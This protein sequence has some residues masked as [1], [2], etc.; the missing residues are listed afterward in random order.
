M[1][2][3]VQTKR[4]KPDKD[5][6][7]HA[8]DAS[9]PGSLQ[10]ATSDVDLKVYR[11]NQ[12][13]RLE[14]ERFVQEIELLSTRNVNLV[15]QL[16]ELEEMLEQAR[17]EVARAL[18]L[19]DE[20]RRL[21]E[22]LAQKERELESADSRVKAL[23]AELELARREANQGAAELQTL[24]ESERRR[25]SV[26]DEERQ[27]A[28]RRIE[29]L[30]AMVL[31]LK[32]Q[33]LAGAS[34][35]LSRRRKVSPSAVVCGSPYELLTEQLRG[36]LGSMASS[37]VQQIYRRCGFDQAE[38]SP[39]KLGTVL[40]RLETTCPKLVQNQEEQAAL[41][42][43][44]ESCRRLLMEKAAAPP[45]VSDQA[46]AP[47]ERPQPLP[48]VELEPEPSL[49][50]E[51]QPPASAPA[52]EEPPASAPAQDQPP[53][54]APVEDQPSST[55]APSPAAVAPSGPAA[56]PADIVRA[57]RLAETTTRAQ[58][59]FQRLLPASIGKS[60][61]A[62]A[63]P[64]AS[65]SP[66]PDLRPARE[67]ELL[68]QVQAGRRLLEE[69]DPE[70]ALAHFE[71][72]EKQRSDCLEVVLG[73]FHSLTASRQWV[74]AHAVGA[75]LYGKL[76]GDEADDYRDA[77][78]AVLKE[79]LGELRS[80]A[81]RKKVLLELAELNL[82]D[83]KQAVRYLR[84]A[85]LLPDR[86][87][88][89][90]KIYYHLCSLLFGSQEDRTPYLLGYMRSLTNRPEMFRH[91]EQIY[92]DPRHSSAQ[93][94]ARAVL[95]LARKSRAEAEQMEIR[96][97]RSLAP[98]RPDH[99]LL[100]KA[101]TPIEA[102]VVKF[103]LDHLL[104]LSGV[105]LQARC[106]EYEDRMSRSLEAPEAGAVPR[107]IRQAAAVLGLEGLTVRC[108]RDGAPFLLDAGAGGVVYHLHAERLPQAELRFLVYRKLLQLQRRHLE[109]YRTAQNLDKRGR[110]RLVKTYLDLFRNAGSPIPDQLVAQLER[111]P[112]EPQDFDE[113]LCSIL[114]RLHQETRSDAFLDLKEFLF[115]QRPFSEH[116]D[117]AADR[118]ASAVSGLSAACYALTRNYL[119]DG[120]LMERV[121]REGLQVLYENPTQELEGLRGRLQWLWADR[122]QAVS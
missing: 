71:Q 18:R 40:E 14:N 59:F 22:E 105:P 116:L 84:Q 21:R 86:I 57:P 112:G 15:F 96:A 42:A 101:G 69:G 77:M 31:E 7:S 119:G 2:P 28:T 120:P 73:L 25:A 56:P 118:F 51:E 38:T 74:R 75:R 12:K 34:S 1:I 20:A 43:C 11:Q 88:D 93:P 106:P 94:V 58:D 50:Y 3:A 70:A 48:R 104:P 110:Y 30:E 36:P 91:I 111:L 45:P 26:L 61:P 6:L 79:R 49:E 97:G 90:G 13:L 102:S 80:A 55:D 92:A 85:E 37:L 115:A 41:Q 95:S 98:C 35:S 62:P 64:P 122:L 109:L 27:S 17:L 29:F 83:P 33:Y 53:A 76:R 54:S 65:S 24:L 4:G 19:E 100:D 67:R 99:S 60:A 117:R 121:T 82:V 81:D 16:K 39:E 113:K 78:T 66:A 108:C 68:A 32:E 44:L 23:E 87:P 5:Q 52:Q 9:P 10:P 89:G 114:D 63:A 103:C 107:E 46:G 72:L 8:R 47:T